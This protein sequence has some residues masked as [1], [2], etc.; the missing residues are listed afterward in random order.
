MLSH[1]MSHRTCKLKQQY[2]P[3]SVDRIW[4]TA[5]SGQ[6]VEQKEISVVAAGGAE[7]GSHVGREFGVFLQNK[8]YFAIRSSKSAPCYLPKGVENF[9]PHKT[10]MQMPVSALFIIVK[11]CKQPRCPSVGEW[12]NRQ[13]SIQT[14]EYYSAPKRNLLPSHEKTWMNLSAYY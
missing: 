9:Y 10:Y 5:N 2:T 6:D 1:P 3:V 8:T 4:N 12:I 13:W 14:M 7:W 11:T